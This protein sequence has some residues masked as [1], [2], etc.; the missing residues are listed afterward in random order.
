MP[1]QYAQFPQYPPQ[2]YPPPQQQP[3]YPPPQQFVPQQQ[4]SY[5]VVAV[6][7]PPP[8][9]V[10]RAPIIYTMHLG[11]HNLDRKDV[12]SKSDP[13]IIISSARNPAYHANSYMTQGGHATGEW[14]LVHKTETI[15]NNHKPVYRPFAIDL[16]QLCNGNMDQPFLVEVYDWDANGNHDFIGSVTTTI[17]ECQVMKEMQLRN[18][19]RL[20]LITKTAGVLEVLRCEPGGQLANQVVV[21]Q[22]GQ[23]VAVVQ[24]TQPV[25][26]GGTAYPVVGGY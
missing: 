5:P 22:G 4:P 13:F 12:F 3:H 23:P 10:V 26:Q 15:M 7:Q 21:A 8:P 19:K 2:H 6:Q 1:H 17:R 18:P 24:A 25:M 16:M 14:Q 11:C 20:S 9:V